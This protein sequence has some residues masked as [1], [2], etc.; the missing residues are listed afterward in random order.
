MY[1]CRMRTLLCHRAQ[2]CHIPY[3]K[4][5]WLKCVI[6]VNANGKVHGGASH[7]LGDEHVGVHLHPGLE[8][9]GFHRDAGHG[10][11]SGVLEGEFHG[12]HLRYGDV[13]LS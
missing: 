11:A 4:L 5:G 3:F 13:G 8:L 7:Q 10:G 9:R 1:V 6:K 12:Y 2:F